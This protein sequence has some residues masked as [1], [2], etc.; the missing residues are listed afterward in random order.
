MSALGVAVAVLAAV[1]DVNWLV[2]WSMNVLDSLSLMVWSPS[3]S[4][5]LNK[6]LTASCSSVDVAPAS[7]SV[8]DTTPSS[9]VSSAS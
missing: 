3:V 5:A 6:A 1:A 9:L 8:S 2:S 7:R 4:M